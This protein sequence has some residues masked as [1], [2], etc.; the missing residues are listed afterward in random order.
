MSYVNVPFPDCI[1]FGAQRTPRWAT[2]IATTA[3]GHTVSNE[4]WSNALHDY[5]VTLAV[6]VVSNYEAIKEHQHEVR[7]RANSFPFKDFA[8]FAAAASEGV[9]TLLT[10]S[11][12]QMGKVYGSAN[13]YT[14]KI[15]RPVSGTCTFYRTRSAVQSIITPTVDYSTG[16]FTV[17]G[18]VSG[19]TY[20]W[21]GEFRVPCRYVSDELPAVAVNKEPGSDGELFISA[22]A[23]LLT[24]DRDG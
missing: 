19:D 21:A 22:A 12:Y 2:A 5:D 16:R 20:Q 11:T 13:P 10:G 14:R 23:I 18:H 17:T 15:T 7:G 1:A 4:E 24:E 3:G 6:R 9:G 8:D